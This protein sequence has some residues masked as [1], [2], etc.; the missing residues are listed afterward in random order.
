MRWN[1][2][3]VFLKNQCISHIFGFFRD[4]RHGQ[5]AGHDFTAFDPQR[6]FSL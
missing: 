3:F 5:T 1:K 4:G 6:I 2:A